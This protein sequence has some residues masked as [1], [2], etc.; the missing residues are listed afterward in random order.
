MLK[1]DMFAV[2][3]QNADDT[4]AKG[5][6]VSQGSKLIWGGY[7]QRHYQDCLEWNSVGQWEEQALLKADWDLVLEG[8][9]VGGADLPDS[10]E[11]LL[12]TSTYNII[13][14]QTALEKIVEVNKLVC[15]KKSDDGTRLVDCL[16]DTYDVLALSSCDAHFETLGFYVG[17]HTYYMNK[18]NL[19]FE[20]NGDSHD[21]ICGLRLV[22]SNT[23]E[24]WVLG[25][26][27]MTRY[28]TVFDFARNRIGFAVRS[29][30][31]NKTRC[32]DDWSKDI[33]YDGKP[34]PVPTASPTFAPTAAPTAEFVNTAN[35][36]EG[37]SMAPI[38]AFA[39]V[40]LLCY[41]FNIG[42]NKRQRRGDRPDNKYSLTSRYED[43]EAPGL[44]LM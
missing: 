42:G 28:Y 33:R 20:I 8:A 22:G 2:Y 35:N 9:F 14:P 19:V 16:Q 13:G 6:L 34:I 25:T 1:Y 29:K 5:D 21:K 30:T 26:V 15:Y 27:F 24:S 31:R 17:G 38:I 23:T 10:R 3:A 32:P 36:G 37:P 11:A 7:D 40:I 4:N 44:E 39:I 12:D 18:D 41:C 43:A